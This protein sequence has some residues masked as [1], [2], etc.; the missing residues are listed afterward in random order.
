MASGK[1][2]L[3]QNVNSYI[4]GMNNIL[5]RFTSYLRANRDE[6]GCVK[7]IYKLI[8]KLLVECKSWISIAL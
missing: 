8:I 1:Q 3:P 4:P 2:T 6:K 7:D 5:Q